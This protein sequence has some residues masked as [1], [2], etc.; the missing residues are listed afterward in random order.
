MA[1]GKLWLASNKG[2]LVGVDAASGKVV[3]KR[4][5]DT[6]VY[7]SPVVAG[8]RMFVLTDKADLIAMN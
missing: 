6:P 7:I 5:L 1:G 4:D 8:G 3:T 2:L